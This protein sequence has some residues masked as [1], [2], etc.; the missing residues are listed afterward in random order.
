MLNS[1]I[2]AKLTDY[3]LIKIVIFSDI[4]KNEKEPIN[5]IINGETIVKLQI[6]K[7]TYLNGIALYEC[8]SPVKIE[9]GNSYYIQIKDFGVTPLNVNDATFFNGF[10]EKFYYD[11]NDL[12]ATYSNEK[13][14]FKVWAPLA[15]KV[16]LFIRK[17]RE[18]KFTTFVMKRSYNGVYS[19][20]LDGDYDGFSYRYRVTNSGL[21]FLTTDPYGKGSTANGR[22]SVVINP[23]KTKINLNE[24]K[25]S[26]LKNNCE[27]VIYELDVRDFTVDSSTDIENKGKYLGL[28]EENRKTTGKHPA[29]LDYLKFI[30]VSHV[31]VLPIY[32]F[33][34]IDE[35]NPNESYNW[36]Y[37]PQQYFVPEGS[38]S[39]NPD[40]PYSRII[41]LKKMIASLHKNNIKVNMDVVF[42]HV[43]EYQTSV[44]EKIVPNYYFRKNRNGTLSNG[45]FCGNDLDSERPMVRK[46]IL[47]CLAF[48]MNEYGID[49]YRFDLMGLI[50]ID[51]M[52]MAYNV[53]KSIKSDA[54]FYGEG[55]NMGT[56][57]EERRT[58]IMNSFKVPGIGFFN[59]SFRDIVRGQADSRDPGYLAGNTS[60]IE[61][62]KYAVLGSVTNYCYPARFKNVNQSINYCECHDNRTIFDQINRY[63]DDETKTLR[64]VRMI[65]TVID[66]SY[67]VSFFH[68]GQEI[69]LTKFGVDNTYNMG[70]KYNKF[71]YSVLDKR[72]EM[73]MHFASLNSVKGK[74]T[75]GEL[76]SSEILK[77]VTFV[78]LKNGALMMKLKKSVGTLFDI[79][80]I[81]NPTDNELNVTLDDY[82]TAVVT[83]AGYIKNSDLKAKDITL[84]PYEINILVKRV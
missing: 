5:L 26:I 33:K 64:I 45:S 78:D 75:F 3:D 77:N 57:P 27:A 82:Y 13:T 62:F 42:N 61:G 16:V 81:A 40:D 4:E 68:A 20:V 21:S 24:D 47:D 55:W 63:I 30:N 54:M 66:F 56:L 35:L 44:F 60:Y 28:T 43:Y 67:G 72:F 49:G 53:T 70:D 84:N 37:D 11:G 6:N 74:I 25:L 51:T 80:A 58:S 41:E 46:M 17:N 29:G 83:Y 32:D 38:Y 10:D 14:S 79:V 34:T 50:D 59:D 18:D 69:G 36:G 65:N 73:A 39:T 71:D 76:T 12:G 2:S 9:L 31:Q 8:K 19:V 1:F 23:S 15:S 7:V 52:K 48:W 22:D